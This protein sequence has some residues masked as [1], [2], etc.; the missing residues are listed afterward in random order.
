M[1]ACATL[2]DIVGGPSMLLGQ[3]VVLVDTGLPDG[4]E[5]ILAAV[6]EVGRE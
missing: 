4:D 1:I 6:K 5:A 3:R 2:P